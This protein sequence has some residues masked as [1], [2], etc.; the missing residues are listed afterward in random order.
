MQWGRIFEEGRL[1]SIVGLKGRSNEKKSLRQVNMVA[2]FIN[3]NEPWSCK[4]GRKKA[5]I[6][7]HNFPV[8]GHSHFLNSSPGVSSKLLRLSKHI[9]RALGV[10]GRFYH[11][12]PFL[13]YSLLH[14][15]RDAVNKE[16][17]V[18]AKVTSLYMFDPQKWVFHIKLIEFKDNVGAFPWKKE[19]SPCCS[20]P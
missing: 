15:S 1:F 3:L 9:D 10:M 14:C 2:E 4:Y 16:K 18:L 8:R 17:Y 6:D 7:M 5:K 19:N 13:I 12:Q 20:C 11:F